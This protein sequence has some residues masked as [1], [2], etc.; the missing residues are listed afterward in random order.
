MARRKSDSASYIQP[1]FSSCNA[2]QSWDSMSSFAG[3]VAGAGDEFKP[4]DYSP[5]IVR[6]RDFGSFQPE[7]S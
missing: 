5:L 6:L 4:N 3:R 1:S 2:P 7:A